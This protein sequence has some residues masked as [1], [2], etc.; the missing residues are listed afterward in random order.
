MVGSAFS[1]Y[2][3]MTSETH[4][5][6]RITRVSQPPGYGDPY[7]RTRRKMQFSFSKAKIRFRAKSHRLNCESLLGQGSDRPSPNESS[8]EEFDGLEGAGRGSGCPPLGYF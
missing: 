3:R 4:T 6:P 1:R 8:D 7:S 2:S 5:K